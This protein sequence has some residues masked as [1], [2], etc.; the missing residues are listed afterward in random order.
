[1]VDKMNESF[2]DL[3]LDDTVD[4]VEFIDAECF[5]VTYNDGGVNVVRW[6]D[7]NQWHITG[8]KGA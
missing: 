2:L 8:S 5:M 3:V 7:D 1:M 6:F 4:F